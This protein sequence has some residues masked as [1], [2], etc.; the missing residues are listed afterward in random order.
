MYLYALIEKR[1]LTF[2]EFETHEVAAAY[3]WGKNLSKYALRIKV[4]ETDYRIY[5]LKHE[6]FSGNVDVLGQ[7][8]HHLR[9]NLMYDVA[10]QGEAA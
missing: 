8:F 7:Q 9:L 4:T 10:G 2:K 1:S 3:M 5:D 6:F